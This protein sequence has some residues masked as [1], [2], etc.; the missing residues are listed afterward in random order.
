MQIPKQPR[1][2][3]SESTESVQPE[4]KSAAVSQSPAASA[5]EDLHKQL[6]ETYSSYLK[7]VTSAN[8][9]AQLELAKSYYAYLEKLQQPTTSGSDP[10]LEYLKEMIQAHGDTQAAADAQKKFA[11]A[12]VDQ[13]AAYQKAVADAATVYL[14]STRDIWEKLQSEVGQHNKEI[15]NALKDVLLNTE[16]GPTSIPTLTLLYQSIK[17]MSTATARDST[18]AT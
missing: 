12:R 6:Q 16:V 10:A 17:T 2:K 9:N 8:L 18:K 13:H 7:N 5:T 14:Q 15:A 1:T 3:A 4:D 11:L